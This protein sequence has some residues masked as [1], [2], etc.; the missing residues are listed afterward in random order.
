MAA[1]IE[2]S[3]KYARAQPGRC[4]LQPVRYMVFRDHSLYR[5]RQWQAVWGD[6]TWT[7]TTLPRDHHRYRVRALALSL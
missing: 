4:R 6:D 5:S 1:G 7:R 2:K 3:F